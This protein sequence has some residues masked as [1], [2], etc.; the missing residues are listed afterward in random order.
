VNIDST[1]SKNLFDF[2]HNRI[3][4]LGR[5]DNKEFQDIDFNRS[6]CNNECK[7]RGAEVFEFLIENLA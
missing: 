5:M 1:L 2:E 3:D 7:G 6:E 4:R